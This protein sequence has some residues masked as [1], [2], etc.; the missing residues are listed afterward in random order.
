[1]SAI[2]SAKPLLIFLHSFVAGACDIEK[3][4]RE[5]DRMMYEHQREIKELRKEM[6]EK[7]S[8]LDDWTQNHEVQLQVRQKCDE[9]VLTCEFVCSA[10]IHEILI[11]DRNNEM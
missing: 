9:S 7:D 6:H 3:S 10:C 2:W 5:E 4:Q 8:L 1:V 11:G